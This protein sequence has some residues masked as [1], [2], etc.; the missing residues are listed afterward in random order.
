[1]HSTDNQLRAE[2]SPRVM[3]HTNPMPY[4]R[5][6]RS[7][8]TVSR[9][10]LGTMTFGARTEE[11]EARRIIVSAAEAGVN[12]IDTADTYADGRSEEITG[13]AIA[14]DRHS[15]VLATKLANP[16][17]NGPNQRGLSRKWIIQ[18][19][20][21]SLKRLGTDFIDIL[22]LHKEDPL[23]PLE[24]TV[25]AVA[26]L[27]RSGAIRYFGISNFKAWRIARLC[28][29]CD[30]EGI[31]RPIV[32]QPLY[33]ALNR[34]AE[35]EILPACESLG[36]GIVAYSPTARGVLSGKYREGEPPPEGSR[37]ALQNKRMMETEYQP[38]NIV[39]AEAFAAHAQGR[40]LEPAAFA[41]AWV[42][43]NPILT[44]AIAGP[45][46]MEQWQSY[47]SALDVEWTEEDERLVD[48]LVPAGTTA[49]HQSIDPA[50]PIEGRPR[51]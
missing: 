6:G 27:Q 41:T 31:D 23:T 1:M 18:E 16:I 48:A 30:A 5:L 36:I 13:R 19:A 35:V 47:L 49:A 29:I 7:G 28:A 2:G 44:G 37:A 22:Y 34:T 14:A 50:Y 33:H 10:A 15:W 25:R 38:E 24:E 12:F 42:L 46:T 3:K 9:I 45:R 8:L 20:H 4:R 32:D 43:A 40:G 26:D 21:S 51:R 17:G 39:A 11:G